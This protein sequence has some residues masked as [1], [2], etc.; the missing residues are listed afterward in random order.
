MILFQSK[1]C[2]YSFKLSQG[3]INDWSNLVQYLLSPGDVAFFQHLSLKSDGWW[4]K[5]GWFT[6]TMNMIPPKLWCT[7][8]HQCSIRTPD[9]LGIY[10]LI[11]I[12]YVNCMYMFV[13]PDKMQIVQHIRILNC[14]YYICYARCINS[15]WNTMFLW[16]G[17][18]ICSSL[19]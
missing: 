8:V 9:K 1:I 7:S 3:W 17:K 18:V 15:F 11:S 5:E 10:C 6:K 19:I 2:K 13:C 16:S 14:W 12:L 4:D